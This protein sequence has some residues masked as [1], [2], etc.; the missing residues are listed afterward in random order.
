MLPKLPPEAS[1]AA[2][3]P[4]R[5]SKEVALKS[6]CCILH[7]FGS[8]RGGGPEALWGALGAA[9]GALGAPFGAPVLFKVSEAISAAI[10]HEAWK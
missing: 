5:G 3:G 10:G 4:P 6:A 1:W 7:R 8:P 9:L 2:L